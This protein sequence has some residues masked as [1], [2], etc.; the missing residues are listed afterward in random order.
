MSVARS[1]ARWTLWI[2]YYHSGTLFV[3]F[4]SS[5]TRRLVEDRRHLIVIGVP[6][7]VPVAELNHV[8]RHDRYRA[9]CSSRHGNAVVAAGS[10]GMP[11]FARWL[12][13]NRWHS[14]QPASGWYCIGPEAPWRVRSPTGLRKYALACQAL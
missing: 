6:R 10:A 1:V 5:L 7:H 8:A 3:S 12:S 14:G 4:V 11:Q 13:V 9:I 2:E